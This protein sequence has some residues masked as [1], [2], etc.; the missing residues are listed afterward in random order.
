MWKKKMAKDKSTFSSNHH[1]IKIEYTVE[2]YERCIV[3]RRDEP[4]KGETQM[5]GWGNESSR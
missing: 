2:A 4:W 1:V 5:K 3:R